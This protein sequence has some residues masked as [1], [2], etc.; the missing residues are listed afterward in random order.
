MPEREARAPALTP[1]L[2]FRRRN[3]TLDSG[4]KVNRFFDLFSII[5]RSLRVLTCCGPGRV[6]CCGVFLS[7]VLHG[8]NVT[9]TGES[10]GNK[11]APQR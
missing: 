3:T 11:K 4:V 1:F 7:R 10:G 8:W 6:A 2:V 5:L 9:S